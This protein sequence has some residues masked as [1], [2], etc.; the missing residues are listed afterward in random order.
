[1]YDSVRCP[2]QLKAY[3][4]QIILVK[5]NDRFDKTTKRNSWPFSSCV[6]S[7]TGVKSHW[8]R[9][10]A[11]KVSAVAGHARGREEKRRVPAARERKA[12]SGLSQ[13]SRS[14]RYRIVHTDARAALH[15]REIHRK[16]CISWQNGCNAQRTARPVRLSRWCE[17]G[18][19]KTGERVPSHGGELIETCYAVLISR[20]LLCDFPLRRAEVSNLLSQRVSYKFKNAVRAA[21][22]KLMIIQTPNDEL[23]LSLY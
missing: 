8:P 7:A 20:C 15:T 17:C 22:K 18:I 21:Y 3:S 12:R 6:A 13:R 10:G 1:M 16:S 14:R 2:L 4:D 11:R 9:S 23:K 19:G 5:K